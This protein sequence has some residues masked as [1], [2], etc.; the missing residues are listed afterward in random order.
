MRAAGQNNGVI[1]SFSRALTEGL[2]AQQSDEE[3]NA[4]LDE[5]IAGIAKASAPEATIRG[6]A[7]ALVA[8][9]LPAFAFPAVSWWWLAWVGLV[10]LLFVVRAAR[11]P[12]QAQR[13]L[14]SGLTAFVLVTQYWLWPSAGPAHGGLAIGIGALWLPWGWA[15]HRLLGGEITT[16]GCSPLAAS[17]LARGCSPRPSGHGTGSAGRGRCSVRRSGISPRHSLRV[18]GRRLAGELADCRGQHRGCRGGSA[19]LRPV[20]ALPVVLAALGPAWF[21][22]G[23]APRLGRRSGSRSSSLVTLL[24]RRARQAASE[25][26]TGELTGQQIDLVVWGESSVGVDLTSDPETVARLVDLVDGSALTCWSTSTRELPAGGIYKSSVLI[27]PDGVRGSYA[28]TRL[29]PFGEYVPLRPL[30]GWATRHTQ[31]AGEDR[32]RGEG[33]IVLTRIRWPLAR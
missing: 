21:W 20:F 16:S 27:G 19:A 9:A 22:V 8:G 1:A 17:S 14:G 29:V 2:T 31:A 30:F 25:T 10:P 28:K 7:A 32:R 33:P 12:V 23:P 6:Y 3:F 24:R 4:T 15:A 18:A 13:A 26:L 5:A 11:S